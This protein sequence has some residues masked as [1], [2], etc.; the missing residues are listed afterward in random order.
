M[1]RKYVKIYTDLTTS[2]LCSLFPVYNVL[3]LSYSYVMSLESIIITI[4]SRLRITRRQQLN[5]VPV[6]YLN[7]QRNKKAT[8]LSPRLLYFL[9][10]R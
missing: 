7:F 1:L 5:Q 8:W 2:L 6:F 10:F 9:I 3:F 4:P